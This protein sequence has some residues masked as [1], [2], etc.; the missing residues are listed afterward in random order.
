M[1][2]AGEIET[3]WTADALKAGLRE[4]LLAQG[5]IL[6]ATAAAG[7]NWG[8]QAGLNAYVAQYAD[9]ISRFSISKTVGFSQSMGGLCG[10]LIISGNLIPWRGWY[11]IFPVC[12][13]ANMY[14]AGSGTF[15]T[16]INTAYGCTT[17]T[18]AA[19]TAGHDPLLT[20]ASNYT[21]RMRYTASAGD[22]TVNKAANETPMQAQ[23]APFALESF[24]LNTIGN[25]GDASNFIP[26]DMVNF[27]A[28]C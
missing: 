28:R 24:L 19:L 27:Y 7:E 9:A 20:T 17:G 2:G 5:H 25:H 26:Y 14:G 15:A 16:E 1:H 4:A 6:S 11:G 18:Y 13:L 23:V 8:N 3:A 21:M 10:Q 12:S 22:T